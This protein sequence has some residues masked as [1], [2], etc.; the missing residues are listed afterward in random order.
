MC[1]ARRAA[2]RSTGGRWL[3]IAFLGLLVFSLALRYAPGLREGVDRAWRWSRERLPGDAGAPAPT[4]TDEAVPAA[5]PDI[6]LRLQILNATGVS[7]LALERGESLRRWGVDTLDKTNA[8]GWPF[9]ETLLVVRS[10]REG[11]RAAVAALAERM[12]GV[13][14]IVQRRE[15]LMLDATLVLGHDWQEYRWP[16]P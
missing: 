16:E 13:P 4:P 7:R 1:A 8:P 14:V 11:C 3:L 5:Q 15:D 12:G 2:G 10:E 6:P 9:P